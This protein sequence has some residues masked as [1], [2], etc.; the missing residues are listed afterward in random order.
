MFGHLVHNSTVTIYGSKKEIHFPWF[1]LLSGVTWL[2]WYQ[3]IGLGTHHFPYKLSLNLSS[4]V[5]E[6]FGVGTDV[7]IISF[8]SGFMEP[9]F[10]PEEILSIPIA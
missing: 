4:Y 9:Y 7:K 3:S 5:L 10:I 6:I 8:L 1:L 2:E